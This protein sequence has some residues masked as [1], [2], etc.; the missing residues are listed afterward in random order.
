MME[1]KKCCG[2]C[3]HHWKHLEYGMEDPHEGDWWCSEEQSEA[4][5]A[6]TG[7]GDICEEWEAKE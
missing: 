4:Y 2:T 7:Y 6:F 1:E 5:G 3:K